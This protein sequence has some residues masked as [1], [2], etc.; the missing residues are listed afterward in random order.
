[1]G[2][3]EIL[4]MEFYSRHGCFE[5]EQIIGNKFIVDFY[6]EFDM[7]KASISDDLNDSVNY[8]SVYAIISEEMAIPSKMIERVAGR[9]LERIKSEFP[10]ISSASVSI[11]KCSPPIGGQVGAFKITLA[12]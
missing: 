3:F 9:I 1:M 8:P 11:S 2:K 6:A 4:N 12:Y 10:M 7:T 5:E